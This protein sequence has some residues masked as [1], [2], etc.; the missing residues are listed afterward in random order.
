MAWSLQSLRNKSKLRDAA[1]SVLK[2]FGLSY[3][4]S[5]K[6]VDSYINRLSD[7][8]AEELIREL[9]AILEG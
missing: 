3:L 9:K 1:Q 2:V 5:D 7:A 4:G 6:I 8:Q